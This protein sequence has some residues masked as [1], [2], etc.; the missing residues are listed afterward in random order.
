MAQAVLEG[1][2]I[3]GLYAL[4]ALGFS[5]VYKSSRILNL[6][7]G[8]QILILSYLVMFLLTAGVPLGVT[9]PIIFL[10]GGL[11]GFLI[12]RFAIR[13]LLGQS[14]LTILM[15]TLM[16]GFLFKGV[17]ALIWGGQTMSFPFTPNGTWGG[18]VFVRPAYLYAFITALAIFGFL[19][20]LFKYTKIGLAMRV[21]AA[22]HQ[23]SQSL[24]IT[25][26]KI[27]S[28]S[29]VI[30]G[31]LSAICAIFTGMIFLI[32]TEMGDVALGNALPV[33]LLGGMD[34][35]PGALLGGII[36]GLVQSIGGYFG[37]EY[38]TIIPWLIMLLILL[39]RPWG[40][41]GER[42]IERI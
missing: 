3:G 28:Y 1:I 29:W 4:I 31:F 38:E 2:L 40:L 17:I 9:I 15:M 39:I 13:P 35:I 8:E 6:A 30:A 41:L 37:P 32:A 16:L 24:G 5:I 23:V 33:L 20:A 21:V 12:E 26:R 42:R 7:Y 14:F 19:L 10:C 36:I 22:D 27:F 25:V 34:S 18:D 11:L